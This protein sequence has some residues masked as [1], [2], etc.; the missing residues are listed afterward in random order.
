MTE[1]S[2]GL[3]LGSCRELRNFAHRIREAMSVMCEF[4]CATSA[5]PLPAAALYRYAKEPLIFQSGRP[6]KCWPYVWVRPALRRHRVA[7]NARRSEAMFVLYE[8]KSTKEKANKLILRPGTFA[9]HLWQGRGP[10]Q[11]PHS[12]VVGAAAGV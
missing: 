7:S 10:P 9:W 12:S 8:A 1:K 6:R 2:G 5:M 11:P 3:G 4:S